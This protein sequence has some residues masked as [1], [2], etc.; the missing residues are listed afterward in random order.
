MQ[1]RYIKKTSENAEYCD[2]PAYI[3]VL[4]RRPLYSA[5]RGTWHQA[6]EGER[7]TVRQTPLELPLYALKHVFIMGFLQ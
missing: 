3:L 4:L 2:T 6:G 1:K 5:T 7:P